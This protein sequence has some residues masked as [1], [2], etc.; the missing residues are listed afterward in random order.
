MSKIQVKEIIYEED[1]RISKYYKLNS[2]PLRKTVSR[3]VKKML[4]DKFW[5]D[6]FWKIEVFLNQIKYNNI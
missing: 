3:F 1:A 5:I 2:N 4:I 6:S